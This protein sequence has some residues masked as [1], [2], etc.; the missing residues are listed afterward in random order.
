MQIMSEQPSDDFFL[1]GRRFHVAA[2]DANG[3]VSGDTVLTFVHG[4]EG[5]SARYG[6]GPIA[7]GHLLGALDG[8]G[9]LHFCYVQIDRDRRVDAG[10]ST[11][12]V[13]RLPDGRLRI[14]ERFAWF[15]RDGEGINVFEEIPSGVRPAS[16]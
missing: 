8:P 16:A 11:A 15:T 3:V 1:H 12:T 5:V 2:T 13:D 14:T 10:R 6:G 7:E 9:S 4:P